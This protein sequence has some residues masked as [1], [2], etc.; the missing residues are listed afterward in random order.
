MDSPNL[1]Y[2]AWN[3][4]YLD[5]SYHFTT[6]LLYTVICRNKTPGREKGLKFA[7]KAAQK[8]FLP[9]WQKGLIPASVEG[10]I[11]ACDCDKF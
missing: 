1:T 9:R 7:L 8:Q 5:R 2:E 4:K 3:E 11:L 10:I 6:I